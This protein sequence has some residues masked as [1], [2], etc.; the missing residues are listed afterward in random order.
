MDSENA[1]EGS[2]GTESRERDPAVLWY[3]PVQHEVNPTNTS[4]SLKELT[5]YN[6]ENTKQQTQLLPRPLKQLSSCR[7]KH[8]HTHTTIRRTI[9]PINNSLTKKTGHISQNPHMP[10]I[11]ALMALQTRDSGVAMATAACQ[12]R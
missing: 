6:R 3:H 5:K 11:W 9:R 10:T 2:D 7:A 8:T 1:P 12:C 4:V